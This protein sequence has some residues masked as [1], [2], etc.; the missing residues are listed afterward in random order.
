MSGLQEAVRGQY[1][2]QQ[3][4]TMPQPLTLALGREG[5]R[6]GSHMLNSV[7]T[8]NADANRSTLVEVSHERY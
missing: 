3:M 4:C 5:G 8:Y 6:H 2:R 7:V 1:E